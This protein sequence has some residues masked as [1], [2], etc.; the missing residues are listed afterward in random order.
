MRRAPIIAV[1]ALAGIAGGPLVLPDTSDDTTRSGPELAYDDS[2]FE[3][4]NDIEVHH[5][6]AGPSGAPAVLLSHHF[7]GSVPTWRHVMDELG[8]DHLVTAFDRPGFGL[9]ERKPRAAWNGSNPYTRASAATIGWELLDH[10]GAERAVLVGSS[11]GGTNV[12]E[13]YARH[14]ERVRALVLVS[15]AITGDVGPPDFL[16]PVL[17][18]PQGRALAPFIA[19][20]LA[21]DIGIERISSSWADP[22]RATEADAEPYQRMLR[23]EGWELGFWELINAEPR[24]DLREVVRSIDVPTLLVTGDRDPVIAPRWNRRTAAAIPGARFVEL[25]NCGHTPQEEC[26]EQLVEV[27]RDF[28][29]DLDG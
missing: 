1:L 25:E 23:V 2:R 20:R 8:G 10:L 5:Q 7:Y 18:G 13:M 3:R 15:P 4:F 17:R 24:P 16:R 21:S 27:V 22:S 14:P 26:P 19:Q 6:V 29:D 12:L 28:L 11:A 9:T